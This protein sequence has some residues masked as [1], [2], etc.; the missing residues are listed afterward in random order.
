MSNYG[1]TLTSDNFVEMTQLETSV[2][3]DK[4]LNTPKQ[5][6]ADFV[7][8][9]LQRLSGI[10]KDKLPLLLQ[11]L[12]NNLA[13][14]QIALYAR[15]TNLEQQLDNFH[16]TGNIVPTD[17]DYLSVIN[18]NL[19]GT[20]TDLFIDQSISLNSSVDEAG[21]I[22]NTLSITRTNKMP[23]M[24]GTENVDYMRIFVPQGARLISNLGFDYKTV[25]TTASQGYE[26]DPQVL[27]WE[28]NSVKDTL[29]NTAIG[30][31]AGKTYFGNWLTTQ[32]GET[33]TVKLVY[34]TC[35]KVIC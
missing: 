23:Q 33:K 27:E 25:D 18:S 2:Y 24:A 28:K 14:K 1:V 11:A 21:N 31:E 19:G 5:M 35:N 9:L 16:W 15:D 8:I 12:Q 10:S 22:T 3:Y 32:G 34:E 4:V 13:E 6:L 7:P 20:K 30:Q 17:R 29:T 26:M